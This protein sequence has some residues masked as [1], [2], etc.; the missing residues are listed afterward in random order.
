MA[1]LFTA[2]STFQ[3]LLLVCLLICIS[4]CG[5]TPTA[6]QPSSVN[7]PA[8]KANFASEEDIQL[9]QNTVDKLSKYNDDPAQWDIEMLEYFEQ[10]SADSATRYGKFSSHMYN[11]PSIDRCDRKAIVT[12]Q[13]ALHYHASSL[14]ILS[15]ALDCAERF[16]RTDQ[17]SVIASSI[18]IVGEK[19]IKMTGKGESLNNPISVRE[20]YEGE[21]LLGLAGIEVFD[22]EI[23]VENDRLII[24]HHGIDKIVNRY[25]LSYADQSAF[26]I[27]SMTASLS[28]DELNELPYKTSFINLKKSAL[29]R[30]KHYSMQLWNLRQKLYGGSYKQVIDQ[31]APKK[32]ISPLRISLLAQAYM[33]TNDTAGIKT[34]ENE[35]IHYANLGIPELQAVASMMLLK[36][37]NPDGSDFTRI[38]LDELTTAAEQDFALVIDAFNKSEETIGLGNASLIWVRTLLSDD[39]LN[40]YAPF[41]ASG[42]SAN[43]VDAWKQTL[44]YLA[45]NQEEEQV[46]LNNRIEEFARILNAV[47]AK[48]LAAR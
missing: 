44:D 10:T 4:A 39:D 40:S 25:S 15:Y 41:I 13:N 23:L 34:I 31:L 29:H 27:R 22:T 20:L 26:F 24:V 21:Y 43:A 45:A 9:F 30:G 46:E 42:L 11:T 8:L 6:K 28:K 12:I 5:S 36:M 2:K 19:L 14:P 37:N 3:N 35:L 33:A 7:T 48:Q 18:A 38:H 16:E 1:A 47:E 32:L 17:Q